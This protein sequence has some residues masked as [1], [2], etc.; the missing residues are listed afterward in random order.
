MNRVLLAFLWIIG[1]AAICAAQ[2]TIYYPHIVNGAL[3]GHNFKTTIFLTNPAANGGGAV[4]GT[5]AFKSDGANLGATGSELSL[6]VTTGSGQVLT[7]TS[8]PFQ[9]TGG[10]SLKLATS[11]SGAF[12]MGFAVV[13]S[14]GPVSGTA[15]FADFTNGGILT[16]EAGVPAV[17]AV[18]RQTIFVDTMG[19]YKVGVAYANPASSSASVTLT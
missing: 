3:G 15:T 19:G 2:S 8:I 4:S 16:G 1:A 6:T 17:A 18:P 9:L 11:G 14:T 12:V 5:V 7:G 13:T 10:Q